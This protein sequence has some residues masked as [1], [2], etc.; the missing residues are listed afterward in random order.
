MGQIRF[1]FETQQDKLIRDLAT[2]CRVK[3][4]KEASVSK[5]DMT[6]SKSKR[7][8]S[9]SMLDAEHILMFFIFKIINKYLIYYLLKGNIS[10]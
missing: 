1:F 3:K 5:P 6:C 2:S 4:E 9:H 7:S 10:S 8:A